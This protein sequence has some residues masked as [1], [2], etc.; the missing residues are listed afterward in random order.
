MVK[1]VPTPEGLKRSA[2]RAYYSAW[3]SV[4]EVREDYNKYVE[5]VGEE[6]GIK[7]EYASKSE[8][9][10]YLIVQGIGLF[11]ELSLKAKVCSVSPYLLL[12]G[13]DAKISKK[14]ADL[15][16][17]DLR[18]VDA[19]ELPNIVNAFC[20]EPLDDN[21]IQVYHKYRSLRNKIAHLGFTEASFSADALLREMVFLY[22]KLWG[23][24]WLANKLR[25][26]E[27]HRGSFFH[28]GRY[29]S[30]EANVMS[31]L[32]FIYAFLTA[33]EFKTLVGKAKTTRR[34]R[35][36]ECYYQAT[37]KFYNPDEGECRTAYLNDS[38]E[39]LQCVMCQ[40]AFKVM[41]ES[42]GLGACKGNVISDTGGD[43]SGHCHTCG[44]PRLAA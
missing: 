28:D 19:F 3:D 22:A 4:T 9:D 14:S 1:N 26:E 18:T 31:Q 21:F 25:Y 27:E 20:S 37:L 42:C 5:E 15:D 43:F 8:G 33:G 6:D 2:L 13:N 35:C 16:F 30:A 7:E 36:H 12:I 32:E 23:Q 17:S 10:F 24:D 34:Y 44:E 38:G 40:K 11:N 41:R 39:L 29:A